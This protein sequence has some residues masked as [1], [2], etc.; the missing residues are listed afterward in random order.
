MKRF[1]KL[2]LGAA[3]VLF[4]AIITTGV[5][6]W[7]IWSSNLPYIG[8]LKEY[9]P[10]IITEVYSDE[11]E[12]IG[13]FWDEKRIVVALDRVPKNL[14]HAF[15]AAEDSRFFKHE[16]VD[17]VSIVRAFFKNMAAGKI[18]QGG[19][20][21][22]QQVT[23]SLLLKNPEKTYK[24][25]VREATLSLQIEKNFSK[26]KIL[27]LYL[28]QIYL[29]HGAYGVEAAAQTYFGKSAG[30]LSIAE[31]AIMAG[32][33]QAP[34]RYSL[35][36]HFNRAKARQKYVLERMREEGFITPEQEKEA[37]AA[38]IL[39]KET[40]EKPFNRAPYFTEHIRKYLEQKYGRDLLYRG[41]MKVY[42]TLSLT[43]QRTAQ[44]AIRA[45]LLELDKREG[46]R[47]PHRHLSPG[48]REK[49]ITDM[50]L[51]FSA[52]PLLKDDVVEGLVVKV[53][54]QDQAVAVR[55]GAN[56]GIIP[57]SE[58]KWARRPDPEVPYYAAVVRKPGAVLKEGDVVLVRLREEGKPPYDWQLSLEQ[59]PAAQGALFCMESETG[60][61]R[62]M[63]GGRDF[64][65]SQ[66]NRAVQAKR[67]PGSAFKPIIYAAALD[68]GMNPATVII[69]A[70]YI[71]KMK[72][73]D[74]LWRPKN[75]AEKFF[76][77]TLFR[78]ALIKSRNVITVKILKEIGVGR[79]IAYARTMGIESDLSPDLSLALGSSGLSLLE[80]TK[81]YAVF[82]NGGMKVEPYFIKRIVDRRGEVLEENQPVLAEAISRETACV[83]T[84]LLKGVVN[85]GTGWRVRALKRPAAGKTGTTND[86]RDAWFIGYT[87]GLVTG[88]WVGYDDRRPMGKGET[89]SR[90]ASPIWLHFMEEVLSDRP[91]ED[92]SAPEG[93]VFTKIDA[94]TGLLASPYSQKTVFQAF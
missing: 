7:Y 33:A 35:V 91:K 45:G 64:S 12:V 51:E 65:K 1:L 39:T 4:L 79:A 11:G 38:E 93:V 56:T 23:K 22:T 26:E 21:I 19:S 78:T 34:S 40:E 32:L 86:L 68:W 42:T 82:D 88:A 60:R 3:V 36:L 6:L 89:G 17:L 72:K 63:V 14:I 29:G 2:A 70:P 46:Y 54:D 61:V 87:P 50:S 30:E 16:G 20:T 77:P 43:M 84:D 15:I 76:G 55:I 41:G 67:Q 5:T 8:S 66:F 80:I 47:G 75:Y 58:M 71:S 85:E 74:D 59:E 90:A 73:D 28:N 13:R 53:D 44:K 92:F 37:L 69:D 49:F 10:P 27:F 24:R 18:E 94:K 57:L 48:D 31:S 9:N 62:A 52:G 25:K 81:A 83:M